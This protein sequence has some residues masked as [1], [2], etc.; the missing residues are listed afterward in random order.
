MWILYRFDWVYE[1]V[2]PFIVNWGFWSDGWNLNCVMV[3]MVFIMFEL[4]VHVVEFEI[5]F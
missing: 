1:I 5:C 2:F 4:M 3:S